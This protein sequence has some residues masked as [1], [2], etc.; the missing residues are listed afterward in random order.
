MQSPQ[1]AD[2]FTITGTDSNQEW[3]ILPA[4]NCGDI[5]A[6]CTAP[7]TVTNGD[8]NY[9]VIVNKATGQV[10]STSGAGVEAQAPAAPSNGDW[11]VRANKG[12][13]W[14]IVPARIT[15]AHSS[16]SSGSGHRRRAP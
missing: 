3:D 9:Y 12:Q 10:L 1:A 15:R 6:N 2:V 14:R 13:L 16:S 5:P 11:I 4:G 8:G 7:P